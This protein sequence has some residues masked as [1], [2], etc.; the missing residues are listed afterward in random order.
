MMKFFTITSVISVLLL[1]ACGGRTAHPI[2]TLWPDD[3]TMTCEDIS[4][5]Q[6]RNNGE[7]AQLA[8]EKGRKIKR[9][10][11]HACTFFCIF[12]LFMIDLTDTQDIEIDAYEARNKRL[13]DLALLKKCPMEQK[14]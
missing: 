13:E 14:K 1:T 4:S 11:D 9:N 6:A 5:E 2:K 12:P 7:I 8:A 3:G 10:I